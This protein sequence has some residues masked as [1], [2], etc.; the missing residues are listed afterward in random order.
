M[1]AINAIVPPLILLRAFRQKGCPVPCRWAR[2]IVQL[3][4]GFCV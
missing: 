3:F 1:L 4:F 2:M